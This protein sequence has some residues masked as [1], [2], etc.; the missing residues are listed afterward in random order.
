MSKAVV[1]WLNADHGYVGV[2]PVAAAWALLR[3]RYTY[4]TTSL[5]DIVITAGFVTGLEVAGKTHS[6][7]SPAPTIRQARHLSGRTRFVIINNWFS[8]AACC[9]AGRN[10]AADP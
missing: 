1:R 5:P 6:E 2:N 4:H 3:I 9:M 7:S 10:P 8:A